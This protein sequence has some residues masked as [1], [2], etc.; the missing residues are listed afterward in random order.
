MTILVPLL[1][2][3]LSHSLASLQ[4]VPRS[5]TVI[6]IMEVTAE[7]TYVRHHQRKIALTC[8]TC[9]H[10]WDVPWS[11]QGKNVLCP[12]CRT[13]QRVPE[14]KTGK[15]DWRDSRAGR[16]TL[17]RVE[18][19]MAKLDTQ[20]ERLH[21]QMATSAS[22]YGR[23]GDLQR[24]LDGLQAEKDGLELAPSTRTRGASARGPVTAGSRRGPGRR[25]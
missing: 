9:D 12:D 7:A 16:P 6:V 25:R 2:D 14:Q 17:A 24:D 4:S 1:G 18:Q 10:K 3:Q 20:I 11:M 8:A 5:G 15:V 23:L 21:G 22:D 19:Q 13:R